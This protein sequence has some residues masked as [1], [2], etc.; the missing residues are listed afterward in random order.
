MRVGGAG[1]AG[2][3]GG[4]AGTTGGTGNP[5]VTNTGGGG[6]GLVNSGGGTGN[7]GG[8]G[9]VILKYPL[10]YTLT[11]TVGITANTTVVGTNSVTRI[12]AGTGTVT[13]S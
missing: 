13:F 7:N 5:G 10:G 12:T 11:G 9:I 8:S 1:A 6:G 3:G 4:G 2:L